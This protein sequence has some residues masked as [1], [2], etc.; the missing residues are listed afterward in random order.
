M[1]IFI[2]FVAHE[3]A[4]KLVKDL[5]DAGLAIILREQG[6]PDINLILLTQQ[7]VQPELWEHL[8]QPDLITIP[9]KIAP[10]DVPDSLTV[11]TIDL[12]ESYEKGYQRLLDQLKI[13]V[14]QNKF[15]PYKGL[16]SYSAIDGQFFFGRSAFTS[17]LLMHIAEGNQFIA[18]T[19]TSGSG[20]TSIVRSG[21]IPAL[22]TTEQ[23]WMPVYIQLENNPI[24]QLSHHL[25][26]LSPETDEVF[27]RL[28]TNA[29]SLTQLL[30]EITPPDT[31]IALVFDAFE[32]VF[33][34]FSLSDRIYFLD[35]LHRAISNN[36][37]GTLVVLALRS[38]F[39]KKL[40][41]YPK[42]GDLLQVSE[43]KVPQL[44]A[45][46]IIEI[47]EGPADIIGTNYESGLPQQIVAEMDQE[48][49]T[50]SLPYLSFVLTQLFE[51][52]AL[53]QANYKA[54]GGVH[55]AIEQQL[56][57]FLE[58]LTSMQQLITQRIL[59]W[60]VDILENGEAVARTLPR[61]RFTF[62]WAKSEEVNDVIDL[63]VQAQLLSETLNTTTNETSIGLIHEILPIAWKRF[64]SWI[65]KDTLSLRYASSLEHMAEDWITRGY[66]DEA[67][68]RGALLD[69]ANLWVQDPDHLP[70]PVLQDYV[71][72]SLQLR[73]SIET[74]REQQ[75][76]TRR[77]ALTIMTALLGLFMLII[78]GGSIFS[79]QT[80][81][82]RNRISTLQADTTIQVATVVA[83]NATVEA[84]RNSIATRQA[85]AQNVAAT[86]NA[87]YV[88]ASTAQSLAET[89]ASAALATA[90]ALRSEQSANATA[91]AQS[92]ELQATAQSA[93]DIAATAQIN[94]QSTAVEAEQQLRRYLAS[95]LVKDVNA[96]LNTDPQLALRLAAEAGSIA[97]L[98]GETETTVQVGQAIRNAL[99]AN[100]TINLGDGVTNS[101]F[102]GNQFTAIDFTDAADELWKL[103]PPQRL[104]TFNGP[105]GQII[106]IAG[107]QT[108]VIDYA[109]DTPDELWRT[110]DGQPTTQLTGEV[111]PYLDPSQDI[112]T[113]NF[114]PLQNATYFVLKYEDDQP[115][116]LW[117]TATL[118][119]IVILSG[120]YQNIVPL[121]DGYFFV[122][123]DNLNLQG[124]IRETVSGQVVQQADE[125]ITE[126]YNNSIFVLRQDGEFDEIWRT[127]PFARLTEIIGR[128]TSVT[129]IQ[130]NPYF[131]V[132]YAG[133]QPAQIWRAEPPIEVVHT[134]SGDIDV[135]VSFFNRQY[136]V[137]RYADGS[138]SELWKTDPLEPIATFNGSVLNLD[139]SLALDEQILITDYINNTISEMW[140]VTENTRV[141]QLSG[142]LEEA[143]AIVGDVYFVARY[144]S[145]QPA[146]VWSAVDGARIATLGAQVEHVKDVIPIKGGTYLLVIYDNT[147]GEIWQVDVNQV[148]LLTTLPDVVSQ[149]F[150]IENGDY[151]LLDFLNGPAEIWQLISGEKIA[152]LAEDVRQANYNAE[153]KRL[154][155][156]D[157]TGQIYSIDFGVFITLNNQS[158]QLSDA[159]LISLSC[160]KLN[161]FE[162]ITEDAL[163]P[164]LAG[165]PPVA[166]R[167]P[168]S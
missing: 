28:E 86:L 150:L 104:A 81:N 142:N 115:S 139:L 83:Q 23:K 26:Q 116:D 92:Q 84:D 94:A 7:S 98:E 21:L 154:N 163:S 58:T 146:E 101:W 45:P 102:L 30:D 37:K 105:I 96:L 5:Q 62:T 10:C 114:V 17:Q 67:L 73:Q 75:I 167:E 48:G 24:Q 4:R 117:E 91:L 162:P 72:M 20:K 53:T 145:S 29:D 44:E 71:A 151:L 111:A 126:P 47:I 164:Y 134:F 93:I 77:R 31:R 138:P 56:E 40:L 97:F 43:L 51:S 141:A 18:L 95:N 80:L 70:S 156:A 159:D 6:T 99:Q 143:T 87:E 11:E 68:L 140:S 155:Y 89:T 118:K 106:P 63:L 19:G 65:E 66:T 82:D 157:A 120:D 50:N 136:F 41:E 1:Q 168:S 38:D 103:N 9:I 129:D 52:G 107:G 109:D 122:Q 27:R 16:A 36:Q 13:I 100:A 69:E 113:P 131:I 59:V 110:E 153:N 135:S 90:D 34:R 112:D 88:A 121:G 42:W 123:Y 137:V 147:P 166:C 8:K 49:L 127:D 149:A 39:Q 165:L 25:Q 133:G 76:K 12:S 22:Q 14:L 85:E 79:I 55:G 33:T 60:L 78:I 128:A 144:E 54:V 119:Q 158:A 35:S 15:N 132:Q 32:N 130:G 2:N 64:A 148:N 125:V 161:E 46:E 74:K 57:A 61:N 108:F 160:E 152:S 124:E 3:T